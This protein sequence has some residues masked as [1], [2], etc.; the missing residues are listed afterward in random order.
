MLEINKLTL[1]II[2][3]PDGV[4]SKGNRIRVATAVAPKKQVKWGTFFIEI[5]FGTFMLTS[6]P[7]CSQAT[8]DQNRHTAIFGSEN[9]VSS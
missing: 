9:W 2:E 3:E 6:C 8:S 5:I 1:R 7:L 4:P